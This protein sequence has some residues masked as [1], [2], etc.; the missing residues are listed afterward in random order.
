MRIQ[1]KAVRLTEMLSAIGGGIET[2]YAINHI[3]QLIA[4]RWV[5]YLDLENFV[6]QLSDSEFQLNRHLKTDILILVD[7]CE[8][9][10]RTFYVYLTT[11][12]ENVAKEKV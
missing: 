8:V 12:L 3:G 5:G 4:A 7:I 6:K 10:T 9:L 1:E 2:R 11:I